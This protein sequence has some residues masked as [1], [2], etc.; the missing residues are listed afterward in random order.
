MGRHT[1]LSTLL[2]NEE[3]KG[4]FEGQGR[5]L[6]SS[7]A[8]FPT[9]HHGGKR[10]TKKRLTYEKVLRREGYCPFLYQSSFFWNM[11]LFLYLTISNML[12]IKNLVIQPLY[13]KYSYLVRYN[14]WSLS[15]LVMY[16]KYVLK[17]RLLYF[18][19]VKKHPSSIISKDLSIALFYWPVTT[20]PCS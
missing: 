7:R 11:I 15:N 5:S 17:T 2:L 12:A 8:K 6:L 1:Y 9:I 20:Q 19:G 3:K 10:A 16:V 14:N 18:M 13:F 4:Y